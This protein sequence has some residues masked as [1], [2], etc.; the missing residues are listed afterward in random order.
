[1]AIL[2]CIA[3]DFTGASDAAS[4][5]VKGGLSTQL[6]S[7]VPHGETILSHSA[8]AFVIALKTRTMEPQAAVHESLHALQ[9]LKNQGIRIFYIKYCST[10]DSRPEGNI[11]PI[12][13]AVLE[14]L[15]AKY[16]LL[17]PSL[18]INGRTVKNGI[19]YV[20]GVPLHETSMKDHP[21]TPMWDSSIPA[22]MKPQGHYACY[23]LSAEELS[24]PYA[25]IEKQ[26]FSQATKGNQKHFYVVP[27][28]QKEKD[29]ERIA[30]LFGH[31]PL[32]TGGSGLILHLAR[33]LTNHM[34]TRPSSLPPIS[35]PALLLAGSCSQA[36][37]SQIRYFQMQGGI[38]T[39]IDTAY[40]F[41]TA[42]AAAAEKIWS[43]I[44]KHW[45]QPILV[46]SSDTPE[47]VKE[48]QK[49][50]RNISEHLEEFFALLA[51]KAIAHGCRRLIIAG[52]ETS[53]AVTKKLGFDTY[54][55]GESVSPGVPIMAPM[56]RPDLRLILK[57][58]NFG[59]ENFFEKAL[60]LTNNEQTG[61]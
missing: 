1:M 31:L 35:G 61:G 33:R 53:G 49:R 51:E 19:L 28:Y 16:T 27:D 56:K 45:G 20:N 36:T 5:L 39:K 14:N 55:I 18:P 12:V 47:H 54:E 46:Y 58:G 52:G 4:F 34:V 8:Q 6:F 40:L 57:S 29:G 43:L 13:D 9:W 38:C 7:G 60:D 3:D 48:A 15:D 32:F 37:L 24:Q 10:F 23:T 44:E 11:G 30:Q 26:L 59:E 17:C 42:P 22:L 2:G 25:A 21:L 50:K 41:Q